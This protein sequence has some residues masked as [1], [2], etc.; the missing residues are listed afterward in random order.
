MPLLQIPRNSCTFLFRNK[1]SY[2]LHLHTIF[3]RLNKYDIRMTVRIVWHRIISYITGKNQ[4]QSSP[5]TSAKLDWTFKSLA[6]LQ[7][8]NLYTS[9][10]Y[11]TR[12]SILSFVHLSKIISKIPSRIAWVKSAF[13]QHWRIDIFQ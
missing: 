1:N 12:E 6:S 13:P 7:C 5:L 8:L 11:F 4:I 3:D 9:T 2:L 10:V